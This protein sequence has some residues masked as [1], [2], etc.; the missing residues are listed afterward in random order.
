MDH[1]IDAQGIASRA[2]EGEEHPRLLAKLL[3]EL[4]FRGS[5]IFIIAVCHSVVLVHTGDGFQN[6]R[7]YARM[8]VASKSSF[9]R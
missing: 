9:H 3:T 1:G 8:V 5:T 4:R 6:L 7:A 2:V